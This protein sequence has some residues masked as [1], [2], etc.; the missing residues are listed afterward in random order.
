MTADDKIRA[1][2]QAEND[3]LRLELKEMHNEL[4]ISR[5]LYS[6]LC[7]HAPFGFIT[8]D[9]KG[10]IREINLTG[11][12]MLG[13]EPSQLIGTPLISQ[14]TKGDRKKITKH[15][16]VCKQG[17]TKVVS[18]VSLFTE[19]GKSLHLRLHTVPVD[20]PHMDQTFYRTALFDMSEVAEIGSL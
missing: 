8:L 6:N 5:G 16:T 18:S 3:E 4:K 10:V 9:A 15:L 19:R 7:E 12:G 2:L 20:D 14:I 13:R 1:K 17:K 11:A